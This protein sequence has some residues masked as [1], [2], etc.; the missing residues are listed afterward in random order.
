[1]IISSP[2]VPL[3]YQYHPLKIN[4]IIIV[5]R[6]FHLPQIKSKILL[7]WNWKMT[8][9]EICCIKILKTR[10]I[11]G[12]TWM[13]QRTGQDRL[14]LFTL[15]S[16]VWFYSVPSSELLLF[17]VL[18]P[19]SLSARV[20]AGRVQCLMSM[21]LSS[22]SV[23]P[24]QQLLW[25]CQWRSVSRTSSSSSGYEWGHNKYC[26]CLYLQDPNFTALLTPD[27]HNFH[28]FHNW[29]NI[30]IIF[31]ETN[32]Q[33]QWGSSCPFSL[34]PFYPFIH[35]VIITPSISSCNEIVI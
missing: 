20:S 29:R 26:V 31:H 11:S 25:R 3:S 9:E 35:L 15:Q 30:S 14:Y 28:N 6:D 33:C 19:G 27:H 22:S 23:C 7:N 18:P 17:L 32:W 2:L 1:M 24:A 12:V 5:E 34:S 8:R 10:R 16:S 21:Q 4:N 13:T